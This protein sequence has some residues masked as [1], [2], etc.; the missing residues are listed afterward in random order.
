M[1]SAAPPDIVRVAYVELVVTDLERARLFW[2]EL[3][4]LHVEAEEPGALYLR[5]F[6]EFVHHSLVL[7][8]G[9]R[10]A[11]A[12]VGFRVRHPDDLDRAELFFKERGC[13]A[14]RV[15]AGATRGLGSAVRVVDP[16]GFTLEFV[17]EMAKVERLVQRFDLRRG[18]G[19]NRLDH[20]NLAVTDVPLAYE[21]Y[22]ALGFGLSETIEDLA[23]GTL[24]AAWMFRKQTV[25]DIAFTMGAGPMI[26]HIAFAVPESHNILSLCDTIGARNEA[27]FIERGPGRHGVSN[28]F[29][30][31]L[32]DD[33]GHRVEV[34]TTDYFTGDPGHETLRWDVHDER[35]R[36]FWANPI[37]P[38]W[39]QGSAPMLD[40]RGRPV[41]VM[42]QKRS[43][44]DVT[45]GA[46]E[47][48]RAHV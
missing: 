10:P 45:V 20:V 33:D 46:D 40:L 24:Y 5:G 4:G 39:Y 7:R 29:Y 8:V 2:V 36:D 31:Y 12:R 6:E 14:E 13:E 23:E 42:E 17:H 15:P 21:H 35:R 41:P 44:R 19:A 9:P 47:I 43:E 32:R 1:N 3:I 37:V 34:Y 11:C 25:H 27:R 26:H 22:T 18:A 30:L 28:A 38:T 48:G 16:L